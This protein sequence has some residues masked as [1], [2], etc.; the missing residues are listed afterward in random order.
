MERIKEIKSILS[1]VLSR[2]IVDIQTTKNNYTILEN[3][4]RIHYESSIY[5]Q[6][7]NKFELFNLVSDFIKAEVEK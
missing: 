3:N 5:F 1:T 7:I 2:K 6:D 4:Y